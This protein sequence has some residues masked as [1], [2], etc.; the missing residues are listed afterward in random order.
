MSDKQQTTEEWAAE[1]GRKERAAMSDKPKWTPGPWKYCGCGKCGFV[2]ATD[3]P[4]AEVVCGDWGD[5]YPS[6]RL[7]GGSINRGVEAYMELIEYGTMPLEEAAANARLIAAA[8]DLHAT[9][10]AAPEPPGHI[11]HRLDARV[12]MSCPRCRWLTTRAAALRKAGL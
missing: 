11:A 5:E 8:P 12:D 1:W 4:V 3:C 7:I 10:E 6:L 2:S 9:L